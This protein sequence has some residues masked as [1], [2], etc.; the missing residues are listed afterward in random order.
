MHHLK[1]SV[2]KV[3]LSRAPELMSIV[4]QRLHHTELAMLAED[5]FDDLERRYC[6]PEHGA[7]PGQR[8]FGCRA[9]AI[10]GKDFVVLRRGGLLF[11]LPQDMRLQISERQDAELW[12][13]LD[14]G[15]PFREWIFLSVSHVGDYRRFGDLALAHVAGTR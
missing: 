11:K 8:I 10:H 5:A 3:S 15:R 4:V 6:T 7:L 14:T 2:R 13:P 12:D 1:T 9:L